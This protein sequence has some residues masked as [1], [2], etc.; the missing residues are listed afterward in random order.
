MLEGGLRL[1]ELR[2]RAGEVV[3]HA[4]GFRAVR[5]RLD[6]QFLRGPELAAVEEREDLRVDL[7]GLRLVRRARLGADREQQRAVRRRSRATLRRGISDQDDRAR[8]RVDGLAAD[9]ELRV[10]G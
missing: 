9:G 8:G 3:E 10:A 2:L 5:E 6:Q 4:A 7:P 1:T